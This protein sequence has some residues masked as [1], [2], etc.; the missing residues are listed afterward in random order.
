MFNAF[1]SPKLKKTF[2]ECNMFRFF[3]FQV[4]ISVLV[5]FSVAVT[6]TMTKSNQRRKGFFG[7]QATLH[8][9][10]KSKQER[11]AG[12]ETETMEEH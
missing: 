4:P 5:C 8:H 10:E 6:S 9:C 1:S 3:T 12:T 11:K 2:Y 7:S